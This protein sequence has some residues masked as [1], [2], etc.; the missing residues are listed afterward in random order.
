MNPSA[1][2]L[3]LRSP[4]DHQRQQARGCGEGGQAR[5]L[6]PAVR[7]HCGP[8]GT[9]SRS[10]GAWHTETAIG[11]AAAGVS[12]CR[13]S[14]WAC[15]T[16]LRDLPPLLPRA[17][18]LRHLQNMRIALMR[19]G[20]LRRQRRVVDV[21]NN[22]RAPPCLWLDRVQHAHCG[23][24]HATRLVRAMVGPMVT[25]CRTHLQCQPRASPPARTRWAPPP[26]RTRRRPSVSG[27][28]S[29]CTGAPAGVGTL[30]ARAAARGRRGSGPLRPP[31]AAGGRRQLWLHAAMVTARNALAPRLGAGGESSAR[32]G[33]PGSGAPPRSPLRCAGG[34]SP[35]Q[36]GSSPEILC[37]ET[38]GSR[39]ETRG[40]GSQRTI[41]LVVLLGLSKH[42]GKR[43]RRGVVPQPALQRRLGLGPPS[44]SEE[45]V[46]VEDVGPLQAC[47]AAA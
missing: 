11:P 16:D 26:A 30:E 40:A 37:G 31:P 24:R 9:R 23:P 43:R 18:V 13:G 1:S 4:R 17:P 25:Q 36:L 22:R 10:H 46:A 14:T 44:E 29:L 32:G 7:P 41:C 42:R 39:R 20:A 45:G 5:T 34:V 21:E 33:P 3:S 6:S 15:H 47:A 2:R 27:H 12:G 38:H 19:H 28:P 35:A 8:R